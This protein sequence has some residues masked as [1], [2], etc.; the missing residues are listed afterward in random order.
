MSE[1]A[2]VYD[3][4]SYE[5]DADPYPVYRWMRDHAPL[6]HNEA[7]NFFALTRFQDNLD[8]FIDR[9]AYT[10]HLGHESRV[11]GPAA[12]GLGADD[13]DG[14]ARAQP[15]PRARE[16]GVHAAPD[17]RARAAHPRDRD[18]A[19]STRSSGASASTW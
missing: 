5:I 18:R 9:D 16:Q 13:L 8:A 11:H 15:L 7:Q 10:L 2:H 6:Y 17:R 12:P 3:P 19:I 1:P 14:P 4:F